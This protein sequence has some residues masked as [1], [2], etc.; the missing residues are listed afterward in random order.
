M[1][2]PN[3]KGSS[4]ATADPGVIDKMVKCKKTTIKARED[5]LDTTFP[6]YRHMQLRILGRIRSILKYSG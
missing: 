5:L 2:K 1:S 3:M 6:P 4:V